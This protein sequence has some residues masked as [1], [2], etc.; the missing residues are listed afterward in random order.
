MKRR[1]AFVL[2][3]IGLAVA[4]C[5]TGVYRFLRQPKFGAL[6]TSFESFKNCSHFYDGKL[7][8]FL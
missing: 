8:S 2:S 1:T 7:L 6:P 5:F 3:G 4:A